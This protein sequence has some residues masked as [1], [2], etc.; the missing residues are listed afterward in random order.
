MP[1]AVLSAS[2]LGRRTK[3]SGLVECR[4]FLEVSPLDSN[5]PVPK[6][7][8]SA[9]RYGDRE[10]HR[11]R[12]R[13]GARACRNT[14][15]QRGRYY[16]RSDPVRRWEADGGLDMSR[17]GL[18]PTS[19]ARAKGCKDDCSGVVSVSSLRGYRRGAISGAKPESRASLKVRPLLRVTLHQA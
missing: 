6:E 12:A 3:C 4:P 5:S 18:H 17:V 1:G 15:S 8:W 10:R 11:N 14:A 7:A 13:H 2:D 16:L 19:G 9:T